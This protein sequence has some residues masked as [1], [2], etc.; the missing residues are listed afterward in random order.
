[1]WKCKNSQ[2][3]RTFHVLGRI[4]VEKRPLGFGTPEVTRVIVDKPCCP[5][6][7]GLEFEEAKEA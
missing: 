2:C 5:F 7:E 4:S 6:C 3:G 1:M